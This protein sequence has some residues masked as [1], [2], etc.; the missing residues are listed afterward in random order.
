MAL[1]NE[2]ATQIT[3][4]STAQQ[5]EYLHLRMRNLENRKETA[6]FHKV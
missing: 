4:A 6:T 2:N 1:R 3:L 5:A